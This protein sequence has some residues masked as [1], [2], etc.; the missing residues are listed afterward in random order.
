M[1]KKQAQA[2]CGGQVVVNITTD[3]L[4]GVV[5]DVELISTHADPMTL[6]VWSGTTS[7]SFTTK[8]GGETKSLTAA[9]RNAL[10]TKAVKFLNWQDAKNGTVGD[11]DVTKRVR[12]ELSR[13]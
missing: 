11:R 5:T 8:A 13:G 1:A 9:Q 6:T 3:D 4:T 7:W 2:V 10:T 12:L